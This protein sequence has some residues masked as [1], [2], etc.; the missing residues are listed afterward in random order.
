MIVT[1]DMLIDTVDD[2]DNISG[3]IKRSEVLQKHA[4]FRVVHLLL[5]NHQGDLLLQQLAFTRERHPGAWGSS[6]AAY[7]AS[8]ETYAQAAQRRLPQELGITTPLNELGKTSMMDEG[9]KKFMTIYTGI[10]EG[11][12]S[13][14]HEHI[15]TLEYCS[16]PAIIGLRMSGVRPFTPTFLH[17]FDFYQAHR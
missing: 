14:D 5:F 13:Y 15:A 1:E 2:H 10:F 6:V 12:F 9:S 17:V 16:I 7:V 4:N 11:T 8:G 3:R